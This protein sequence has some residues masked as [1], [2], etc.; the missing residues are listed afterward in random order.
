MVLSNMKAP[1]EDEILEVIYYEAVKSFPHISE[2]IAHYNRL[3]DGAGGDRSYK[4]LYE[5][6]N[7]Q[8]ARKRQEAV[9][10]S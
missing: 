5:I 2:D 7:R 1:L 4:F 6:V 3:E 10:H 9:R 8:M